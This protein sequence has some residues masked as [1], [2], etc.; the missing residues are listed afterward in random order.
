MENNRE[1]DYDVSDDEA[2]IGMRERWRPFGRRFFRNS[3][4]APLVVPSAPLPAPLP[5]AQNNPS[6]DH[7]NALK[8]NMNAMADLI[9]RLQLQN[10]MQNNF[11]HPPPAYNP[12]LNVGQQN[13]RYAATDVPVY[14]S[15]QRDLSPTGL[16]KIHARELISSLE[17]HINKAKGLDR[18]NKELLLDH[19]SQ[20]IKSIFKAQVK[21]N[22]FNTP[23]IQ[24]T[25][26]NSLGPASISARPNTYN[27][28]KLFTKQ[29][30]IHRQLLSL[31][32][33]GLKAFL[34]QLDSFD[35]S[36]FSACEYNMLIH[37]SLSRELKEKLEM[38]GG[39]PL[40]HS[41]SEYLHKLNRVLTGSITNILDFDDHFMKFKPNSKSIMTI[42]YEYKRFVENISD[43]IISEREKQRKIISA[44]LKYIPYGL[45]HLLNSTAAMQN[46][47]LTLHAFENFLR[48][49]EASID[50]FITKDR[51]QKGTIKKIDIDY[52][53]DKID[54]YAEDLYDSFY[55]ETDCYDSQGVHKISNF[56]SKASLKCDICKRIGHN[57]NQCIYNSNDSLRLSNQQ[58]VRI[59]FC[60]LCRDR[61]H[62]DTECPNFPNI[63][64]VPQACK[65][66]QDAGFYM[67]N[68]PVEACMKN[69]FLDKLKK[70]E[71]NP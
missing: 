58:K 38:A 47:Q 45:R 28:D 67:Y 57:N 54:V 70:S 27:A 51:Y 10:T 71:L 5:A 62:T 9:S 8:D 14:R 64:P 68:H 56:Q 12:V 23:H 26:F 24:C 17:D 59:R 1:R 15:T 61:M 50:H 36:D 40:E 13:Y 11:S 53:S 65:A 39:N 4:R 44:V 31:E 49:H 43:N 42:L 34:N 37:M 19:T 48:T 29:R 18:A 66:C 16:S 33:V 30:V 69:N 21:E 35:L 32:N 63:K 41:T 7:I 2:S 55:D 52:D 25:P 3:P 60:L 46:G 20:Q 6:D 22:T